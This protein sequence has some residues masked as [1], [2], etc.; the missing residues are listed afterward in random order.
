MGDKGR[1]NLGKNSGG[2]GKVKGEGCVLVM[3]PTVVKTK[4]LTVGGMDRD[5]EVSLKS[6]EE[7]KSPGLR[8]GPAPGRDHCRCMT[9]V[10]SFGAGTSSALTAGSTNKD[11]AGSE[12]PGCPPLEEFELPRQVTARDL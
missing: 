8:A 2:R 12:S 6:I 7:R 10:K 5:V 11:V 3:T 4:V 1:H 9:S